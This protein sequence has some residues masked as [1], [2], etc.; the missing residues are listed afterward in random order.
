[1]IFLTR[2][3]G[4][5]RQSAA[6]RKQRPTGKRGLCFTPRLEALEDRTLLAWA[7]VTS[8]PTPR[9]NIAASLAADG[10]IFALGGFGLTLP[11][12]QPPLA[13]A[14][15]YTVNT[16]LWASSLPMIQPSA[17]LAAVTETDGRIFA[18]GG[19]TLG[20]PS[21]TSIAGLTNFVQAFSPATNT[22]Q[23][24]ANMPTARSFLAAAVGPDGR[25]YAI[26]GNA[27]FGPTN[28]VEAYTPA[29]NTWTT[30]ASMPTPRS[31][32]AA[33]TG[34]DGRI[35]AIGGLDILRSPEPLATVEAYTVATNTWTT[36]ASM[37]TPRQ[38][39][40]AA[41]GPDGL[42]YAIGG[43]DASGNPLHTVEAYNVTTN[44]W[45]TAL[46]LP[47]A[48]SGLA[49]VTGPD[50]RIFAIGGRLATTALSTVEA[51]TVTPTPDPRTP[52]FVAQVYLDL[53]HR[54]ADAGGRAA[55][56]SL[57][58]QGQITR[59]QFVLTIEA[60]VEYRTDQINTIYQTLLHRPVDA[61]TLNVLLGFLG[62][63]G[64]Y[65]QIQEI[66]AGSD[67]FFAKSGST[68][69]GF[70][71]ALYQDALGRAPDAAGKAGFDQFLAQGGSRTQVATFIYTSAEFD[72]DL[73]SGF[74]LTFLHRQADAFGLNSFVTALMLGARDE[75][76]IA[77]IVGSD[78]YIG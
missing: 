50:G 77:N 5:E 76:V 56:I 40:A 19:A 75:S 27:A 13:T 41:V 72:V 32:L 78:E 33:V 66:V 4:G 9:S 49:A 34:P 2:L 61:G 71:N 28:I 47:T 74:Y 38:L 14:E 12:P 58:D 64:T 37:P 55:F 20:G 39:L 45:T 52:A 24:V 54:P 48:R 36:V 23:F 8:M 30:V 67:E 17:G 7:T 69:D 26:G 51:L 1:M 44:T 60:S 43:A 21:N 68:N 22:W 70:L 16:N 57:L 29:T 6:G 53:L 65:E 62:L 18:I 31:G 3:A 46:P 73:V 63:G 42:I 25:I 35:Y 11:P 59:T 15:A 10:R